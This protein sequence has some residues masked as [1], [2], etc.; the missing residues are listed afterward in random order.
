MKEERS[1]ELANLFVTAAVAQVEDKVRLAVK[2]CDALL[3]NATNDGGP[4]K[5]RA[6]VASGG[7]A[8]NAFLRMRLRHTLDSIGLEELPLVFPPPALC[9]DNAAMIANVAVGRIRRGRIDG[10]DV[11][12]IAKWSI[13]DC[14][15]DFE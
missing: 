4:T 9:T 6:V 3:A 5:L 7:V 14:E 8:S 1:R 11:M 12:P 15:R 13:Q 10:M 2:R